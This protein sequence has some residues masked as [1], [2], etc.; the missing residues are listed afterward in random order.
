MRMNHATKLEEWSKSQVRYARAK[1][2]G[3]TG[4]DQKER[5]QDVRD[6]LNQDGIQY[7]TDLRARRSDRSD[8][9][10]KDK[11]GNWVHI[12]VKHGAGALAYADTFNLKLFTTKDRDLCLADADYV[13][14]SYTATEKRRTR[15]AKYYRVAKREDFLDMLEEYCHG[16]RSHGWNT[17]VAFAKSR[18]QLNIQSQYAERFWEAMR[19][20][21]RTMCLWDFC[22]IVLGRDPR[23]DI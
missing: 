19:R 1:A 4:E 17:A 7:S 5:E 14:Y 10:V 20:D 13:V 23:W 16:N 21:E 2:K 18:A 22:Q 15:I 12:E 9:V 11:N 3:S 8:I 6:M